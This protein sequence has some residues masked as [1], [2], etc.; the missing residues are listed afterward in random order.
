MNTVKTRL[1]IFMDRYPFVREILK[2][3]EN[4]YVDL[5]G[6]P[7]EMTPNELH[8]YMLERGWQVSEEDKETLARI[9]NGEEGVHTGIVYRRE[10]TRIPDKLG[11]NEL[12][13]QDLLAVPKKRLHFSTKET[14]EDWRKYHFVLKDGT[15]IKD[16]VYADI[17]DTSPGNEETA[18]GE[19]VLGA[20]ERL[21][22]APDEIVAVVSEKYYYHRRLE[23]SRDD[24][25]EMF[26]GIHIYTVPE[27]VK[28]SEL[29]DNLKKEY[30]TELNRVREIYS[31]QEV[32]LSNGNKIIL[33]PVYPE[34][35]VLDEFPQ[36]ALPQ[37]INF[38]LYFD[39][40]GRQV[41]SP[42]DASD[43]IKIEYRPYEPPDRQW[44]FLPEKKTEDPRMINWYSTRQWYPAKSLEE[45]L[46]KSFKILEVLQKTEKTIPENEH[47]LRET[48][49]KIF[50][51]TVTRKTAATGPAL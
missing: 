44:L 27:N 21:G 19:T 25:D 37:R 47:D 50:E 38:V 30:E 35:D 15:I 33:H 6:S 49:E 14:L 13:M 22:I 48:C 28:L 18:A 12:G 4:Y 2:A 31:G 10:W 26:H 46:E 8:K 5:N 3:E 39:T 40:D 20:I 32:T 36:Y 9:L 43:K 41:D 23:L 1:S 42:H 17:E 29:I 24:E 45:G 34:K 51:E 7:G 11:E 16:A